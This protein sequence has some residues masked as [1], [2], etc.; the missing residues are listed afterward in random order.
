MLLLGT[1]LLERLIM[2]GSRS[3]NGSSRLIG[4][5]R[6]GKLA[7]MR[8]NCWR[9]SLL[10]LLLLGEGVTVLALSCV[11]VRC[12]G[13]GALKGVEQGH[14]LSSKRCTTW[15]WSSLLLLLLLLRKTLALLS[16]LLMLLLLLLLRWRG[17]TVSMLLVVLL[18]GALVEDG[19]LD[20]RG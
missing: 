19:A 14:R 7:K 3:R 5:S 1:T 2:V 20:L 6:D 11:L 17:S 13:W 16:K 8:L 4:I 9:N 12:R 18:E 15:C 10:L